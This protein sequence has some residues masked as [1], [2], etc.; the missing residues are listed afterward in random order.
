[1][2]VLNNGN[3]G[4]GTTP[5]NKLHLYTAGGGL[6]DL[7]K[8]ENSQFTGSGSRVVFNN[9]YGNLAGIKGITAP[10]GG[11]FD[12]EG[13]LVFQTATDAVLADRVT[14]KYDGNVGIGTTNPEKQLEIG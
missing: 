14:I 4:I 13:D 11:S 9:A 7:L 8:L 12:N 6:V 10:G 1:M 5:Q 2:T 3:V